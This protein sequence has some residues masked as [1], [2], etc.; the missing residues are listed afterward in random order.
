MS[1]KILDKKFFSNVNSISD[2]EH[3]KS[4]LYRKGIK[5]L[6]LNSKSI[7]SILSDIDAS[8]QVDHTLYIDLLVKYYG[9]DFSDSVFLYTS[10]NTKDYKDLY[11]KKPMSFFDSDGKEQ[12]NSNNDFDGNTEYTINEYVKKNIDH[13]HSLSD[14]G[15]NALILE[16]I[17]IDKTFQFNNNTLYLSTKE[18]FLKM[19]IHFMYISHCVNCIEINL[20]DSTTIRLFPKKDSKYVYLQKNLNQE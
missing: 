4:V 10:M 18:N 6:P 13:L 2:K 1:C 5:V 19:P 3:I 11:L 9:L 16:D 20:K 7:V 8:T 14:C 15:L 12:K 17:K